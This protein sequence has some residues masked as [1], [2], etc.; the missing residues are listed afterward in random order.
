MLLFIAFKKKGGL[1]WSTLRI[2]AKIRSDE[3]W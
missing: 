3:K 1:V 2:G